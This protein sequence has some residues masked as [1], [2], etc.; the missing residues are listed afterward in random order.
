M[1]DLTL[2]LAPGTYGAENREGPGVTVSRRQGLHILHLAGDLSDADF[3]TAARH[4]LGLP[5][6]QLALETR[7][8]HGVR[9]LWLAPNR[10]LVVSS[11]KL[12][13][14]AFGAKASVNDVGQGRSVLRLR[15]RSVRDLL[16]KG[17]PI[18]LDL[19]A[20]PAGHA[21]ATLL[22]HLGVIIDCI[23]DDV[24]DLYVTR[25]YDHFIHDWLVQAGKEFGVRMSST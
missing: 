6:P 2:S 14:G 11:H 13:A 8:G 10:W 25:S 17:C 9:I 7:D 4:A 19:Q 20:F 1:V 18:D 5:L 22:G 3:P 15:G 16:C 24:F 23:A 21:A 12:E